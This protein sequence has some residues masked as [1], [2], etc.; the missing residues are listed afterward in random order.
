M[1]TLLSPAKTLDY[2]EDGKFGHTMPRLLDHSLRLVDNLKKKNSKK[3]QDLMNISKDL[4][5]LN[6]DRYEQF[7]SDFKEE[8]SKPSILAF[9][10]DVYVG[11]EAESFTEN[12]MEFAQEHIRIL[13]G[14][15]GLLR[16]LDLMQPYRLE[17]GTSLKTTRGRNLYEFWKS[18]ITDLLNEDLENQ[19]NKT[20]L[21]LASNEYFKAIKKKKLNGNILEVN[22]KEDREGELKFISFNA[23]KARGL[24]SRYIVKN[25][26][27]NPEDLKGF[28]YEGYYYS[29]DHSQDDEW[30]FIR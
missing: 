13:S 26:I 20:I 1:I 8:N 10:G 30:L 17:M 16:P 19:D 29:A 14:L 12:E 22:F 9:K 28:D 4:A 5:D 15:Y 7:S 6:V 11:L 21:N 18:R 24:M 25:R 27:D 23:K 2:S 3:L